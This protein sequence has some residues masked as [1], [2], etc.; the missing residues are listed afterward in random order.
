MF[1]LAH[2]SDP[3]L[4][5]LPRPTVRQLLS[6][7][8]T[9]F[10]SWS[11]KRHAIHRTE[12]LEALMD[13]LRRQQTDHLVVTGDLVNISLPEEFERSGAWLRR[14]GPPDDITVVPGNHDAYVQI[15]WEQSWQHWAD[16]MADERDGT[17][18]PAQGFD[19]FP[20]V[21]VRGRVAL[22]GAS[23]GLPTPPFM[24][25]GSLGDAQRQR[26]EERLRALGQEGL[27]R[28][29]LIHHPPLRS[30]TKWR[31]CLMDSAAFVE[32]VSRAGAELV[33]HGHMHHYQ[34]VTINPDGRAIPVFGVTSV[35]GIDPSKGPD[36]QAAYHLYEISDSGNGWDVRMTARGLDQAGGTVR[37]TVERRLSLPI[38]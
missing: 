11:Y 18:R 27:F 29:V 3:H 8:V 38:S 21:R 12:V 36:H 25:S 26:L 16:Y 28:I 34:A 19:D 9:G 32:T 4:A 10:L 15:P 7:R 17:P 13:D 5:P 20:F 14:L 33:L 23:S 1:R 2:I 30:Q 24:A 37:D 35:S 31:K 22:V 6:K